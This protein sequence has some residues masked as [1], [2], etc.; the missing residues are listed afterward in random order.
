[1]TKFQSFY[2][3][4]FY[5]KH[6]LIYIYIVYIRI[7]VINWGNKVDKPTRMST[8]RGKVQYSPKACA[9]GFRYGAK[10]NY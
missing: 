9:R 6:I 8:Y 10:Q 5:F 7:L 1:M 2:N 4:S 3:A